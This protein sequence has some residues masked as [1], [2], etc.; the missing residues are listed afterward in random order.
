MSINIPLL[1]LILFVHPLKQNNILKIGPNDELFRETETIT[2][3]GE[4]KF[5]ENC[6]WDGGENSK[7]RFLRLSCLSLSYTYVHTENFIEIIVKH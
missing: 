4:E 6:N 2:L 1:T 5:G 3:L 7:R